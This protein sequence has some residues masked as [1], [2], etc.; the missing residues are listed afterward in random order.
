MEDVRE[1]LEAML[2]KVPVPRDPGLPHPAMAKLFMRDD[3]KRERQK[4][5]SYVSTWD[6]P[7]YDTPIQQRRLLE[8]RCI[9]SGARHSRLCRGG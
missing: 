2:P 4:G 8:S 5:L 9:P 3:E 1:R 6:A 7:L